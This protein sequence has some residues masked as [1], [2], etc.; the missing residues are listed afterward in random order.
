MKYLITVP[1]TFSKCLRQDKTGKTCIK[2]FK[3]KVRRYRIGIKSEDGM[4]LEKVIH[5]SV[6]T[7]FQNVKV[8][9]CR[10]H[11]AHAIRLV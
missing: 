10:F 6:K 11:L 7:V 9:G 4:D 1:N 8:I 3:K 2:L 5:T